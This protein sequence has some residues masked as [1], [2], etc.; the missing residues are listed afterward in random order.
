MKTFWSIF[1][2]VTALVFGSFNAHAEKQEC[3]GILKVNQDGDLRF[4]VP[5]EGICVINKTETGKVLAQCTAGKFCRVSGVIED[6]KD[7]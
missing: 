2:V 1:A 3:K 7:R 6:C 4:D 5:P